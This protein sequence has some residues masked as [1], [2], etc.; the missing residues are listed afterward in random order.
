M[1]DNP[2]YLTIDSSPVVRFNR[3]NAPG[4]TI[5]VGLDIDETISRYDSSYWQRLGIFW[6]QY[7][8]IFI[9]VWKLVDLMKNYM[10]TT[11]MVNAWEIIPWKKIH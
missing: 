5:T 2:A 6:I 9:V 11:Q 4:V 3:L 10:F 8:S 7:L 1:M